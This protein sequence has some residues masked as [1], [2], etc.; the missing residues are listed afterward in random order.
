M[1]KFYVCIKGHVGR[2]LDPSDCIIIKNKKEAIA[3]CEKDKSK[4][5]GFIVVETNKNVSDLYIK[6]IALAMIW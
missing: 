5:T 6:K 1:R 2:L 4:D 3:I